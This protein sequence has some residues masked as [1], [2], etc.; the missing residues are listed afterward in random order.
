MRSWWRNAWRACCMMLAITS[1][2]TGWSH[3]DFRVADATFTLAPGEERTF[4]MSVHYHRLVGRFDVAGAEQAAVKF[5]VLDGATWA[6]EGATASSELAEFV[7]PS[8]DA[9]VL[10]YLVR[11]CDDATYTPYML[12]ARNPGSAATTVDLYAWTVHDDFAV[13]VDRAENG[14]FGIPFVLFAA[15]GALALGTAMRSRRGAGRNRRRVSKA[16]RW[17]VGVALTAGVLALGLG[18]A[19]AMRYDTGLVV[20]LIAVLADLPVPGG[21]FGSRAAAVMGV[22]MLGWLGAVGAWIGSI[23]TGPRMPVATVGA[24]LGGV[25]LLGGVLLGSAYG[26]LAVPLALGVVLGIPLMVAAWLVIAG[27]RRPAA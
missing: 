14:A 2:S 23:P 16:L 3:A 24:L 27:P 8:E 11:C 6:S 7:L 12:V 5:I 1:L 22:L 17:S 15:L 18:I 25:S 4:P 21:P 20:G 9:P 10:N 13:V 26:A 19:G